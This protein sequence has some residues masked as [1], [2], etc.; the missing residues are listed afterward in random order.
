[1]SFLAGMAAATSGP[2]ENVFKAPFAKHSPQI[3]TRLL[4]SHL[5]SLLN[6]SAT[7]ASQN[8]RPDT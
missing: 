1:V 2:A 3:L 4:T 6:V 7:V 8:M 5:R